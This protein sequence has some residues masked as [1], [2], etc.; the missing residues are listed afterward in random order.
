VT[1]IWLCVRRNKRDWLLAIVGSNTHC[2]PSFNTL[3]DLKKNRN[4]FK[5]TSGLRWT[6][7]LSLSQ[8][9]FLMMSLYFTL[10][11]RFHLTSIACH[12]IL[13]LPSC[14]SI[15]LDLTH[16][17]ISNIYV[18]QIHRSCVKLIGCGQVIPQA[19]AFYRF[20]NLYKRK[21]RNHHLI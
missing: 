13:L 12:K 2:I 11:R 8:C 5:S 6:C 10:Y 17:V 1:T 21:P 15:Q 16:H 14:N 19:I 4:F 3:P 9:L 20:C 18:S 7:P